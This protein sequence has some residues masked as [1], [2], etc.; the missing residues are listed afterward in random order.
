MNHLLKA[1]I[2]CEFS[3]KNAPNEK[4][5]LSMRIYENNFRPLRQKTRVYR[6]TVIGSPKNRELR[7][8]EQVKIMAELKNGNYE[9][10]YNVE[11]NFRGPSSYTKNRNLDFSTFISFDNVL[12]K[13]FK[14]AQNLI[15]ADK[16]AINAL[17]RGLDSSKENKLEQG[18]EEYKALLARSGWVPAFGVSDGSNWSFEEAL[19]YHIGNLRIH[20]LDL[21]QCFPENTFLQILIDDTVPSGTPALDFHEQFKYRKPDHRIG[22]RNV[23]R[24]NEVVTWRKI[25]KI[26]GVASDLKYRCPILIV[27]TLETDS[28]LRMPIFGESSLDFFASNETGVALAVSFASGFIA[29]RSEGERVVDETWLALC[30]LVDAK[31]DSDYESLSDLFNSGNYDA[32]SRYISKS[33]LEASEH[34]KE[35]PKR[36]SLSLENLR[37]LLDSLVM[38]IVNHP[39]DV[40]VKV[41]VN[42]DKDP[43][44]E[45]TLDP[46][47]TRSLTG[48]AGSTLI[49]LHTVV[50]ALSRN[51]EV[52]IVITGGQSE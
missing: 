7:Y 20:I 35:S 32:S 33:A 42:H 40:D 50:N 6:A 34:Q 9:N 18:T 22:I 19:A 27:E 12:I 8:P 4:G 13:G 48:E 39:W 5:H 15:E 25:S 14:R 44:L 45:I 28:I 46:E 29:L 49:A 41:R 43:T 21:K 2:I 24:E 36:I 30:R 38:G 23:K 52:Q 16:L 3:N 1:Q 26:K 31:P 10:L 37:E 51:G 47:D 17:R 11:L